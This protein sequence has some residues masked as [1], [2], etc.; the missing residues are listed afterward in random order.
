MKAGG[1]T[2]RTS[3]LDTV[4]ANESDGAIKRSRVA[5]VSERVGVQSALC[6]EHQSL[7]RGRTCGC[8]VEGWGG[9]GGGERRESVS[10]SFGQ[11][12][13][14]PAA[15]GQGDGEIVRV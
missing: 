1:D 2:R 6:E 10:L 3:A 14:G 13:W 15:S 8:V 5:A 7:T 9:E 4:H 11:S 12:N